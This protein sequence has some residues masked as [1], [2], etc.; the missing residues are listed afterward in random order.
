MGATQ[1]M[2]ENLSKLPNSP[3]QEAVQAASDMGVKHGIA[4]PTKSGM[5]W[6]VESVGAIGGTNEYVGYMLDVFAATESDSGKYKAN[7][8]SS[9]RGIFQYMTK[10]TE[11]GNNAMQT[12][13]NRA[14]RAYPNGLPQ[15]LTD[16]EDVAFNGTDEERAKAMIELSDDHSAALMLLD[17]Q[18]RPETKALL[19]KVKEG[20]MDAIQELYYKYHHTN[21]DEATI[22]L[23]E[24]NM[25][26]L[27]R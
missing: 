24:K 16:L 13:V 27:K 7:P 15:W 4:L 6:G 22:A 11:G 23:F 9:A 17:F 12:A 10:H 1:E 18:G 26:K 3:E 5:G 8:N 25:A 19:D 21:P 2:I 14:K 20:D